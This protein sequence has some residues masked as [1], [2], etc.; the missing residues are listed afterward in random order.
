MLIAYIDP[1]LGT[2]IVQTVVAA[3]VGVFFYINKT[4]RWVVAKIRNI[5]GRARK[6]ETTA[7]TAENPDAK[8]EVKTD[9]R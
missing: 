6:I 4:R 2:L 9:V 5:F 1:G 3:F 8:V 7:V